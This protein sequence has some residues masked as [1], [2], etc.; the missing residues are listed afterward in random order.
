MKISFGDFEMTEAEASLQWFHRLRC[1]RPC[2]NGTRSSQWIYCRAQPAIFRW[3]PSQAPRAYITQ[4]WV[5]EPAGAVAFG[6]EQYLKLCRGEY[7]GL[8]NHAR[9]TLQLGFYRVVP[10]GQSFVVP[11]SKGSNLIRGGLE[12]AGIVAAVEIGGNLKA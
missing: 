9:T 5:A 10:L 2:G 1:R 7:S 3:E 6:A 8:R 4:V 11:Q 12:T